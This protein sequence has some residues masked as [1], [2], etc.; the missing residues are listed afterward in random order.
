MCIVFCASRTGRCDRRWFIETQMN[1]D[2]R[3]EKQID[4]KE[5]Q[6]FN[7]RSSAFH[8]KFK[9][10]CNSVRLC[11]GQSQKKKEKLMI[12]T[13]LLFIH[14]ITIIELIRSCHNVHNLYYII[15]F[16]RDVSIEYQVLQIIIFKMNSYVKSPL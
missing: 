1:A 15:S 16:Y 6:S 4:D 2:F 12:N 13:N 9:T 5:L 11:G 3:K 14:I 7:L 10:L 8:Q